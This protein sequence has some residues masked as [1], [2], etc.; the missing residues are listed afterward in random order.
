VLHLFDNFF[1]F[2]RILTIIIRVHLS[3]T[4]KLST[5]NSTKFSVAARLLKNT[6]DIVS[7][8]VTLIKETLINNIRKLFFTK[9]LNRYLLYLYNKFVKNLKRNLFLLESLKRCRKNQTNPQTD[10]ESKWGPPRFREIKSETSK[11]CRWP[12]VANSINKNKML[13]INI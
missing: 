9:R 6:S 3:F 13:P 11:I 7:E 4:L 1:F 8:V 12:L 2:A 10:D 5:I